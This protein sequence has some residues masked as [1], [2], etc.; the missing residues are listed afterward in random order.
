M[1]TAI[2]IRPSKDLRTKY[3]Q[4][5]ALSREGPVAITVNGRQDTVLM[6]HEEYFRQRRYISE[7]EERLAFYA[8]LAQA[9]DDEKLGR[10][11]DA[12]EAFQDILNELESMEI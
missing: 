7:L 3:A 9:A 2:T 6:N 8:H 10:F 4:I 12:E 1:S 11:Q 5:S